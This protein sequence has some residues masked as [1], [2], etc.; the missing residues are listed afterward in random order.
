MVSTGWPGIGGKAIL[1]MAVLFFEYGFV[2]ALAR[3]AVLWLERH[4]KIEHWH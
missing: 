2:T 3:D 1:Y 4:F